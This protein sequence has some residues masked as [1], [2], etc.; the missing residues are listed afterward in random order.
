MFRS[1]E[2]NLALKY[3]RN[4]VRHEP[5]LFIYVTFALHPYKRH[6]KTS[7]FSTVGFEIRLGVHQRAWWILPEKSACAMDHEISLISPLISRRIYKVPNSSKMIS[8]KV[9]KSPKWSPTCLYYQDFAK[10]PLSHH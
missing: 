10:F 4:N 8:N 3:P 9:A 1:K 7:H 6:T 2:A 5:I